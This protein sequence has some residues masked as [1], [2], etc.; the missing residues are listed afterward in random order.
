MNVS[1]CQSLMRLRQPTEVLLWKSLEHIADASGITVVGGTVLQMSRDLSR[2][3][4]LMTHSKS[5]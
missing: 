2:M 3:K 4:V 5:H 1:V